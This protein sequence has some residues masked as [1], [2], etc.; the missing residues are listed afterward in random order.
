MKVIWLTNTP[1]SGYANAKG[2]VNYVA[3]DQYTSLS[4]KKIYPYL[5]SMFTVDGVKY[6][7][8]SPSERTCDAIDCL[9]DESAVHINIGTSVS[10][11]GINMAVKGVNRY[12]F[13]LNDNIKDVQL[14]FAGN[15]GEKAFYGCTGLQTATIQNQGNVG[16]EAFSRCTGL[17]TATIQNQGNVGEE[18]FYG[19]T[20]LQTATLGNHIGS[21]AAEVFANCSA[22]QGIVIPDNVTSLGKSA[23]LGCSKMTTAKVGTGIT[24]IYS[25]TFYG[26]S[27]LTDMQIG[28]NVRTIHMDAFRGC[29]TLPAITIPKAVTLIDN[30][31]FSGCSALKKVFME[32]GET[33]E[34]TLG[35]NGSSPLFADCP[36]DS[37]YI[38]RNISY[39]T[40][41]S[42]GYSPFYRNT[43]LRSIHITDKETEISD[44]EF[45]GCTNLQNV[46]IGDG[47]T[48]IGKWAF[49]GCSSLDFFSCGT[50]V[51]TIGQEAFSD[52]TAMTRLYSW[53]AT[54]PTC[55]SQ[56]LDDINKWSCTL[57]VPQE[58]VSAYQ[59]AEQW[60]EFFF[61]EGV[62]GMEEVE[63]PELKVESSEG[64][65]DLNGRKLSQPK[66][67]L[68]I[69]RFS[70][71]TTKKVMIK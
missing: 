65:Y 71:G 27:S 21:I 44:N 34:L 49:S 45:Y 70:D 38:G 20:A 42:Y 31:A 59:V 51:K 57:Y 62:D 67:G 54:P 56:A 68:N 28:Q 43:S 48:T 16:E 36:L 9:Y 12:T 24:A 69:V 26:C 66:K 55:G 23:F 25:Y 18:A 63:S 33:T 4:N 7:P 2:M 14:S 30:Y 15:V 10:Y 47:V 32:N 13:D 6:V 40:G 60:K 19:C 64:T 11:R 5:S 39:E 58:N 46:R 17:Q 29:E 41:S 52:C 53:A 50:S 1:P 61:M 8:V 22:L 3:N 37:V 35:S